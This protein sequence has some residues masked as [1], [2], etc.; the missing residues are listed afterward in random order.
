VPALFDG[1]HENEA[2]V[3]ALVDAY[4]DQ[5]EKLRAEAQAKAKQEEVKQLKARLAELTR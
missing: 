1:E 5:Q 4:E 2:E 3:I